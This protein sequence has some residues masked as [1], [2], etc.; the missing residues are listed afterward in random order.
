MGVHGGLQGQGKTFLVRGLTARFKKDMLELKEKFKMSKTIVPKEARKRRMIFSELLGSIFVSKK[1]KSAVII[2]SKMGLPSA[3]I[4]SVVLADSGCNT[5]GCITDGINPCTTDAPCPSNVGPC[6]AVAFRNPYEKI[7]PASLGDST[8]S[9][10]V[11]NISQNFKSSLLEMNGI[12]DINFG[13]A[14]V[15]GDEFDA[16]KVDFFED[17]TDVAT[18]LKAYISVCDDCAVYCVKKEKKFLEQDIKSAGFSIP[19]VVFSEFR[20]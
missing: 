8:S 14:L 5:Q 6:P 10:I 2:P 20:N 11:K 12:A 4:C 13:K 15:E 7:K 1:H 3:K 18:I 17:K 19:V 16:T 9:V